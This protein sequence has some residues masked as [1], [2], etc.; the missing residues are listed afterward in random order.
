MSFRNCRSLPIHTI[1]P[2]ITHSALIRHCICSVICHSFHSSVGQ[3]VR[4]ITERSTV[5]ARVGAYPPLGHQNKALTAIAHCFKITRIIAIR[6]IQSIR[7]S[8]FKSADFKEI[9]HTTC[10]TVG[11]CEN[12][13]FAAL[14]MCEFTKLCHCAPPARVSAILLFPTSG[15]NMKT[16]EH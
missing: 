6:N 13:R 14:Q 15:R 11:N 2:E 4:L 12:K 16:N 8:F 3:S 1:I 9:T 10:Q 5:R 7:L